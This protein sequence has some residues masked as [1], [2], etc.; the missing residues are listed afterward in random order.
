M[1]LAGQQAVEQFFEMEKGSLPNGLLLT[2]YYLPAFFGN[3]DFNP[4]IKLSTHR[5]IVVRDGK[6][7]TI[8]PRRY[9]IAGNA[10]LH[11]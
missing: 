2:R 5:G 4:V 1:V 7:L 3:H 8:A 6:T 9:S 11:K 10:H